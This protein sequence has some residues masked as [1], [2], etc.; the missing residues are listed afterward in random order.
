MKLKEEKG[1][2]MVLVAMGMVALLG[3]TALVTDVGLLHTTR[4]KLVN[5]ADAAVLAG[6]QELPGEPIKAYEVA[7]EYLYYNDKGDHYHI[8][9]NNQNT[10]I[11]VSLEKEVQFLFAPVLGISSSNVYAM[12]KGMVGSLSGYMGAAPLAIPDQ[13]LQYGVQYR[14]KAPGGDEHE[15]GSGN[16]GALALG[17]GGASRYEENLKH[18]YQN[19]LR[20][21]DK[22]PTESGN[23]SGPT[24]S[25]LDWRIAQCNH[26]PNCTFDN[27]HRECKRIIIIPVYTGEE[28]DTTKIKKVEI[29]GF[30]A[31]FV[32]NV[33][34][35]GN[36]SEVVG[37]FV[38][39]VQPGEIDAWQKNYGAMGVKLIN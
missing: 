3:F 23:M 26:S 18:G 34:G 30:A 19:M 14:L 5:S 15:L 4:V 38:Q 36:E 39:M 12:S 22:V 11:E 24:K 13:N 25:A 1:S 7:E 29:V 9:L 10:E 33:I 28:E 16:Y 37:R 21:G 35:Q 20:V 27:H 6:A 2:A 17:G 8:S 31:F 32:K